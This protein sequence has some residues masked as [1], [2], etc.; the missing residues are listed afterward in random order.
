M[1]ALLL[2]LSFWF[3]PLAAA[4]DNG[5]VVELVTVS[6]RHPISVEWAVTPSERAKGL[7]FR[8]SMPTDTGMLFD[9]GTE[10]SVDFW[11]KNTPLSLDMVFIG[12]DGTVRRIAK[13]ATPFSESIIPGGASVRY[14][15]EINGGKAD[16]LKLAPG[17]KVLIPAR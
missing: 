5:N 16:A 2:L 8:K 4:V 10:Q 1:A 12:A 6:G 3:A 15:L 9:F 14:V 17:D 13:R 11:M 7:M